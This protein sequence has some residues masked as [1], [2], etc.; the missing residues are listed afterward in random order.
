MTP[1]RTTATEKPRRATLQDV[2]S[3]A[4]V[5]FSAV[6]KVIRGA[7]GV[8]PQMR[9]RVTAAIEKLGYRPHAGARAM[10]GKSYTIGVMIVE[11]SSPF[12]PEVVQGITDALEG[13]P[14]QE[15][16]IAGGLSPARQKR[17]IEALMDRQV[18]GLILVAPWMEAEWLEELGSKI[19]TV[20]VARH[21]TAANFDTV[22]DDEYQ[23]A[24]LMVDHLVSLGHER[25]VH[26]SM[27]SGGLEPFVLSHTARRY[28]YEQAMTRH[29]LVPEIVETTYSETGGYD[30]A[31][32]ALSGK[33]RPT[34]IFAGA[35]IAAL[36]VLRAAEEHGLEV[37]EDLTV[38]GYDNIYVSAIGRI[39]LTTVDQSG[40]LTGANSTRLLLERI[41]GRT[42]PAHYVIAPQL[43]PRHTS[44]APKRVEQA[45]SV[46]AQR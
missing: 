44:A 43:V 33:N 11:M 24:R 20:V 29:G 28:G 35:D 41:E 40:Q 32:Q 13:T 26:T 7:A 2:A 27:P 12:Q 5:S 3:E 17:S 21:G 8:S 16:L 25:I 45:A 14:Y 31:I 34:A 19:P 42:Q 38:A 39:S 4:G 10:R 37:P 1:K 22:V 9:E 30:A 18:D 15:V 6:S 23:G 46:S 36:G